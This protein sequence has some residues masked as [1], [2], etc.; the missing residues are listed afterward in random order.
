MKALLHPN[1]FFFPVQLPSINERLRLGE[2]L[3]RETMQWGIGMRLIPASSK[4]QQHFNAM[5]CG[6]FA[7]LG[8][9]SATRTQQRIISD[10]VC[11]VFVIDDMCDGD[12]SDGFV[13]DSANINQLF[14]S[15]STYWRTG[16]ESVLEDS[17]P[18]HMASRDLR[19]RL[20]ESGAT[21]EWLQ[22]FAQEI[23][24]WFDAAAEEESI[25][26]RHEIMTPDSLM[27]LRPRSGAVFLFMR[28]VEGF[29]EHALPGDPL[30]HKKLRLLHEYAGRIIIYPNDIWSYT[31][32]HSAG[33][34][35][36]LISSLMH[37]EQL[38]LKEAIYRT[39]DMHNIDMMAFNE[40]ATQLLQS[41]NVTLLVHS[42][43]KALEYFLH[44]LFVWGLHAHRYSKNFFRC[45]E[46][47][48]RR[49][50]TI[51]HQRLRRFPCAQMQALRKISEP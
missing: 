28:F 30:L 8:W 51:S 27:N 20:L 29:L 10:T 50:S 35:M 19:G 49:D 32:E 13:N 14:S 5:A 1:D 23:K 36:N 22:R 21:A 3:T 45:T 33:H 6:T 2:I 17:C 46:L 47:E 24:D 4:A 31:K 41:D 26:S 39:V 44:G 34:S 43:M 15:I 25:K 18:L 40:L 42:Y 11:A 12:L 48:S 9:P 37:H 38:D 16:D 7:V